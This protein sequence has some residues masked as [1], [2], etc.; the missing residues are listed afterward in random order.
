MPRPYGLGRLR[1]NVEFNC[2]VD[3]AVDA[4]WTSWSVAVDNSD[5]QL[6]IVTVG[7]RQQ[8]G[9]LRQHQFS[10]R[11]GTKFCADFQLASVR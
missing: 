7:D 4:V 9:D 2:N 6:W 10:R 5:A 3:D 8:R 1:V 11:S